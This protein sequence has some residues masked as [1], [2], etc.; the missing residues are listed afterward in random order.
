M[1]MTA[2]PSSQNDVSRWHA[3][4][5]LPWALLLPGAVFGGF[6]L[7]RVQ[8][9]PL[10]PGVLTALLL[11][12]A[13]ACARAARRRAAPALAV[14]AVAALAV[15]ALVSPA[16]AVIAAVVAGL[17]WLPRLR[18]LAATLLHIL[19]FAAGAA[20]AGRLSAAGIVGLC[21]VALYFWPAERLLARDPFGPPSRGLMTLQFVSPLPVLLAAPPTALVP[22]LVG[23]IFALGNI[24]ICRW[25]WRRR[26]PGRAA[27]LVRLLHRDALLMH[28]YWTAA[29]GAPL[30]AVAVLLVLWHG[31]GR[32]ERL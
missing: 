7:E 24:L 18:P 11:P 10:Q 2:G 31:R 26:E 12:V 32:A 19:A 14:P 28:A 23:C 27:G 25:L 20:A 13:A 15:L 17:A 8:S 22:L 3:A 9:V 5:D 1:A 16:A 21:A 30:W 4:V 29:A 6:W